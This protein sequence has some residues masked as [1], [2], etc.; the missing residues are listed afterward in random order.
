MATDTYETEPRRHRDSGCL[1]GCLLALV[2]MLVLG[3][4]G[5]WWIANNWRGVFGGFG[6]RFISQAI[7]KSDLPAAEKE[8]LKVQVKRISDGFS[9]GTIS[10]QQLGKIIEGV[11]QSPLIP[12]FMVKAIEVQYLEKSGLSEEEKSEGKS[13]IQRFA[14]GMIDHKIDQEGMDRVLQ[15]IAD[16]DAKG[17]WQLRQQVSDD[18]L[19]KF[20][21]AA[22]QEADTAE[23]PEEVV[24][25]D[26]SDELKKIIDQALGII[27]PEPAAMQPAERLEPARAE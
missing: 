1:K 7:D 19:R 10:D 6:A 17:E 8:E 21:D 4:L 27:P 24:E 5:W 3:I 20:L 12:M 9:D 15:H 26:P 18:D 2:V 14:R 13:A 11:G 23:I 25:I 16:R 22:K